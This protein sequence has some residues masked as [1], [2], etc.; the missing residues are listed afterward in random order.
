MLA[1][2]KVVDSYGDNSSDND[3]ILIQEFLKDVLMAGVFL[4][5]P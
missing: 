3:Q 1:I 5:V 2:Q 4:L